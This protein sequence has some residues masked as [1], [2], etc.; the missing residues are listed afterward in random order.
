M[1]TSSAIRQPLSPIEEETDLTIKLEPLSSEESFAYQIRDIIKMV[2]GRFTNDSVP[3][4]EATLPSLPFYTFNQSI[5]SLHL[6]SGRRAPLPDG[7]HF[8]PQR[9]RVGMVSGKFQATYFPQAE[10]PELY[11]PY[12]RTGF[13][14]KL[15]AVVDVAN[16]TWPPTHETLNPGAMMTVYLMNNDG[17]SFCA[18][19]TSEATLIPHYGLHGDPSTMEATLERTNDLRLRLVHRLKRVVDGLLPPRD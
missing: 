10:F 18:N 7:T 17:I 15:T 3:F 19:T 2:Q 14:R 11:V 1:V 4:R 6:L 8:L 12:L 16:H 9:L 5:P 13:P